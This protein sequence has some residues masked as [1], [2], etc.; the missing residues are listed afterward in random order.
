M[1][2]SYKPPPNEES[3]HN[4]DFQLLFAEVS[5]G[6]CLIIFC[7]LY[8]ATINIII[9]FNYILFAFLQSLFHPY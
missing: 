6:F 2:M 3:R 5:S 1:K 8:Y 9:Y 7:R 4:G